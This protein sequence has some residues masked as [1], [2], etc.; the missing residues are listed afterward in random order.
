MR[1]RY[2]GPGAPLRVS[3]SSHGPGGQSSR[4]RAGG[5]HVYGR[6]ASRDLGH[7]R[8]A[9]GQPLNATGSPATQSGATAAP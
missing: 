4:P 3:G 5:T 6:A 1:I 8:G 2:P 9:S 7:L